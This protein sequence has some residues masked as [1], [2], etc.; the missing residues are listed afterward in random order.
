[1]EL[2]LLGLLMIKASTVYEIKKAIEKTF[3]SISSNSVGSIQTALKKLLADCMVTF[4]E[5]HENGKNKKIYELTDK[6]KAYFF[7]NVSKPMLYKEKN[8]ELA[9]FFFMGF[10]PKSVRIELIEAYIFELKIE[11]SKLEKIALSSKDAQTAVED[12]TRYLDE[13]GK[14]HNFKEALNSESLLDSLQNIALFQ[15][16]TLELS[17]AKVDFE[18]EWFEKFK[19]RLE[20]KNCEN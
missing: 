14:T 1:M 5:T 10:A 3:T 7:E 20:D 9:K 18:I 17:L 4:T 11:K 6:G 13:S 12:Y 19:K 15:Y 2:I 16:A 8:M